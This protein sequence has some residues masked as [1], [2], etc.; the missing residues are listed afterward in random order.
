VLRENIV[1]RPILIVS[2][3]VVSLYSA[4]FGNKPV[5]SARHC[6]DVTM[7]SDVIIQ[8]LSQQRN[9]V[10]KVGFFNKRL[11]P[12]PRHDLVFFMKVPFVLN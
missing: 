3:V 5:S 9:I 8:S 2:S 7:S 11:W 4:D 12:K 1:P 10:G 6:F